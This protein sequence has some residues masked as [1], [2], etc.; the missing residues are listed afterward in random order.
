MNYED[1]AWIV[2]E[3]VPWKDFVEFIN[4]RERQILVHSYIY[5]KLDRNIIDDATWS[6]WAEQLEWCF[7]YQKELAAESDFYDIFVN[8]DHST[9]ANID[10][11]HPD[12]DWVHSKAIFLLTLENNMGHRC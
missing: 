7:K 6:L 4:R 10:Y 8:F 5:Y 9:G 12:L 11:T 1:Y 2:N 3:W